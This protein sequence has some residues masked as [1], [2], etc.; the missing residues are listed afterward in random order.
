MSDGADTSDAVGSHYHDIF[1][2]EI[3]PSTV[4]WVVRPY[5]GGLKYGL[6]RDRIER[7]FPDARRTFNNSVSLHTERFHPKV[8]NNGSVQLTGRAYRPRDIIESLERIYSKLLPDGVDIVGMKLEVASVMAKYCVNGAMSDRTYCIGD[9]YQA[10]VRMNNDDVSETNVC[11]F[12]KPHE[13]TAQLNRT[14]HRPCALIRLLGGGEYVTI[15]VYPYV[16]S[17]VKHRVMKKGKL[18]VYKRGSMNVCSPSLA[19]L[20]ELVRDALSVR[21]NLS[22]KHYKSL[23]GTGE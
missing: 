11:V 22:N 8:Y 3:I 4:T 7:V 15:G 20:P 17:N 14:V 5:G 9:L 10:C 12:A 21:V 18:S 6:N 19:S 16:S 2:S 1:K 13:L 23:H